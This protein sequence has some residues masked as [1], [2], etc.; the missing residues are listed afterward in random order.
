MYVPGM[1][2]S[3]T[4]THI[5]LVYYQTKGQ[6]NYMAVNTRT[7]YALRALIE[8][9]ESQDQP[10]QRIESV[11]DRNCHQIHRASFALLKNRW[12]GALAW[13]ADR[14]GLYSGSCGI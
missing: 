11:K 6:G 10:S 8:M 9:A 13:R 7:E 1:G 3:L 12:L 2:F 4:E 14:E 5:K